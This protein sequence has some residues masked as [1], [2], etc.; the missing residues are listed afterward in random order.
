MRRL[1]V[2]ISE[3]PMST[4]G[5]I[6]CVLSVSLSFCL[7]LSHAGGQDRMSKRGGERKAGVVSKVRGYMHA[8]Q[9]G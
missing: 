5:I 1:S 4:A 7:F 3:G 8:D 9:S 6:R 2:G